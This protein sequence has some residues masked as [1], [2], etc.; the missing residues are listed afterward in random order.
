MM[1]AHSRRLARVAGIAAAALGIALC[2]PAAGAAQ[3]V[4][5]SF[6]RTLTVTGPADLDVTTGSGDIVLRTGPAGSV[7]VVGR[8]RASNTL[9]GTG[10]SPGEK[11]KALEASPPVAQTGAAIRIGYI[12]D[13]DLSQNVSI[14]YEITAPAEC[15]L[16][17][18]TGSG[19]QQIGDISGPVDISSGSG[20]LVLGAVG[21]QVSAST[22]SGDITAAGVRG[23]FSGRTGSGSVN[24]S[25]VQGE[26]TVTTGS[27]NVTVTQ[28]GSAAVKV[29]VASGDVRL[30]GINGGLQVDSASGDVTVQGT[31]GDGWQ[32]SSASGEVTL[33]LPAGAA[34][35]LDARTS[36]GNI[37]S[38]HPVTMTGKID[39]RSVTG[40]VRGGGPA[41]RVHTASGN[42]RIR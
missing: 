2:L 41:V 8:I 39:R 25:N 11:V 22:G 10:R 17:S 14:S 31:P 13:R 20:G 29:S 4:Q 24:A 19:D 40:Q 28:T 12:S 34:F 37:D 16:R 42:I 26:V 7:H 15:K 35:D 38:A 6:D 36:S 30:R 33:E 32:V 21:G 23:S 27:G 1:H 9:L 5:G 18:R 3:A